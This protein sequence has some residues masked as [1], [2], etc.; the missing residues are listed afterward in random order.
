VTGKVRVGG[1][2]VS[3]VPV[4][5]Q[6]LVSWKWKASGLDKTSGSG[7]EDRRQEPAIREVSARRGCDRS[8]VSG[9]LKMS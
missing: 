6:R 5:L 1:K 9:T 7:V 8:D 2:A 4:V 3:G